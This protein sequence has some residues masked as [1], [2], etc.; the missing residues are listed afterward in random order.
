MGRIERYKNGIAIRLGLNLKHINGKDVYIVFVR[1]LTKSP[2]KF[3]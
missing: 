1:F 2:V 3:D